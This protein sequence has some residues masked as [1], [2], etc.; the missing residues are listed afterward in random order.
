MKKWVSGF[1]AN[2]RWMSGFLV[3]FG[4][5]SGFLGDYSLA[6]VLLSGPVEANLDV[7]VDNPTVVFIW[8]GSA[9]SLS[10]REKLEDGKWQALDDTD[11]MEQVIRLAMEQWNQVPGAY[12]HLDLVSDNQATINREDG[13]HTIA[14]KKEANLTT[15]AFALPIVKKNKIVDCDITLSQR[16]VSAKSLAY[17]ITHELGHCLGLGHAHTN[18]DAIMGYARMDRNLRLGA[19]DMAGLIYLYPDPKYGSSP[20]LPLRCGTIGG[21]LSQNMTHNYQDWALSILVLLPA[22]ISLIFR[23]KKKLA[24]N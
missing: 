1:F 22:G 9:Q 20:P 12:I 19:D 2:F 7:S 3:V 8:D 4:W 18:Y 10:E 23:R 6:F 24:K 21:K 14:V 15:A 5:V 16:S 13:I 17:T 11:F